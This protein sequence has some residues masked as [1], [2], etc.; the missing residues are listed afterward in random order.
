MDVAVGDVSPHGEIEIALGKQPAALAHHVAE[1]IERHDHVGGG[2]RDRGIDR[3]LR[4]R[5][6]AI[7]AGRDRF[8]QLGKRRRA[9]VDRQAARS[10]SSSSTPRA[11]EQPAETHERRVGACRLAD[12]IRAASHRSRRRRLPATTRGRSASHCRSRRHRDVELAIDAVFANHARSIARRCARWPRCRCR[13]DRGR[14]TSRCAPR[15]ARRR[16]RSPRF[17]DGTGTSARHR[18]AGNGAVLQ[19]RPPTITPSVPSE[20]MKRSIRSIAGAQ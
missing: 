20:P 7:D 17:L 13:A 18:P 12:A 11:I 3:C 10:R 19:R 2:L 9:R 8:A 5:D 16:A 6:A 15:A 1:A 4:L 14:A